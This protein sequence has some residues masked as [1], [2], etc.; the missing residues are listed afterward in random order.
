MKP[1]FL[2]PTWMRWLGLCLF[3]VH[4]PVMHI[5]DM[6]HIHSAPSDTGMFS[7]GHLF[8]I[9]TIVLMVSGLFL[10][11]FA[12]ERIE[13]EQIY[14]LRLSSLRWAIF[15]NYAILVIC[16]VFTTNKADY[17]DMLRLNLWVPLVLFIIIF[18]YKI[19][20]LNRS[21]KPEQ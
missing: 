15:A 11:A 10:I 4:L 13:D 1:H 21:L 9:L 14:Q 12:R 7:S 19:F 6:Y 2:F 3:F 20:R 16:L 18:R 17:K 8:F 5:W